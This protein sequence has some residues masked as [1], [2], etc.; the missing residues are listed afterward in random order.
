MRLC[1]DPDLV[2]VH[3]ELL[4]DLAAARAGAAESFAGGGRSAE[5][6]ARIDDVLEEMEAATVTLV[7]Q[8]LPR[9][10]YRAM[11]D[12]HP[13]RKDADGKTLPRDERYGVDYD[14]FY[15][16]LARCS[17]L[18]ARVDE[19][20]VEDLDADTV[21]LLVD[22]KLSDGQWEE[23]TSRCHRLN[24]TTVDVPFSPAGSPSRRRSSAS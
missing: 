20:T 2:G 1:V 18:G 3:D 19:E 16:E 11:I 9:P 23:L 4:A 5:I 12:A 17:I 21:D 8:A 10:K 22:E 7:L 13:P 15:N 6:Q 24:R 14:A